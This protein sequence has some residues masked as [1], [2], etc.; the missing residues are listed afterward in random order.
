MLSFTPKVRSPYHLS[1]EKWYAMYQN[2]IDEIIEATMQSLYSTNTKYHV[3]V[4]DTNLQEKI[5]NYLYK[6]SFNKFKDFP[7]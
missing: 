6:T 4:Y 5:I 1:K 7:H 2:E 3:R